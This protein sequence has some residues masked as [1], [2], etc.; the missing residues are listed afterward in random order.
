MTWP[1]VVVPTSMCS[2]PL[3]VRGIYLRYSII[4]IT[5]GTG[6]GPDSANGHLQRSRGSRLVGVRIESSV[7]RGE[8]TG[9]WESVPKLYR[10]GELLFTDS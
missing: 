8:T 1:E 7:A 10:K 5:K 6:F 9:K 3:T 4:F 2:N